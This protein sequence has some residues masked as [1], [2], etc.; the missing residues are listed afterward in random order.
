MLLVRSALV[1]RLLSEIESRET[2]LLAYLI[3]HIFQPRVIVVVEVQL[4]SRY[5]VN[6]IHDN[7]RV[8]GLR[9][10]VSGDDALAAFKH[11]SAQALAYSCTIN[12]SALSALSGESLK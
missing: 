8:N 4:L 5:R 12:V 3:C 11:F 1:L 10:G 7:M 2:E 9:V 6:G